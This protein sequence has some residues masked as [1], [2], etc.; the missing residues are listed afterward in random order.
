MGA[1]FAFLIIVAI[2][3]VI[4]IVAVAVPA[5]VGY[6]RERD[7]DLRAR[8]VTER[9]NKRI[10]YQALREIMAQ[11]GDGASL[12]AEIAVSQIDSNEIKEL[13]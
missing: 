3:V 9:T 6:F 8:Y 4:L 5:V 1:A 13:N 11:N 12:I 10:A 7:S 2:V